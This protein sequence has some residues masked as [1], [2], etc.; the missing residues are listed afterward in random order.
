VIA[1]GA[2]TRLT[3]AG[4]SCPDWPGCYGRL[5]VGSVG[6][7]QDHFRMWAEMLHRYSVL[8]L[9]IGILLSLMV[10]LFNRKE[11]KPLQWFFAALLFLLLVYQPILGMWTVTLKLHPSIV[12]QHLLSGLTLMLLIGVQWL[13]FSPYFSKPDTAQGSHFLKWGGVVIIVLLYIQLFLGAWTSTN[14]AA[15]S[16][17][18]FPFCHLTDFSYQFKEAF[19]LLRPLGENYDAGVLSEDARRTIQVVHRLGALVISV[20]L[21][22]WS[23]FISIKAK[24]MR[25]VIASLIPVIL[26]LCQIVLGISMIYF[27]RPLAL[28]LLHTLVAGAFLI[29]VV[30]LNYQLWCLDRRGR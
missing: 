4:L 30:A 12:S 6:L 10:L 17:D 9:T 13:Y 18:T 26:L 23:G 29:S 8:L 28:G 25:L 21:L 24:S 2:F 22:I 15:L 14:Y 19:H 3:D 7:A 11:V 5:Y 1:L 16:C 20:F 27:L